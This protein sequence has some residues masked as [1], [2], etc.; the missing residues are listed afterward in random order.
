MTRLTFLPSLGDARGRSVTRRPSA[1]MAA[2]GGAVAGEGKEFK[3]RTK[4]FLTSIR[5]LRT[6]QNPARWGSARQ[7]ILKGLADEPFSFDRKTRLLH[8]TL[9]GLPVATKIGNSISSLL[10][11]KPVKMSMR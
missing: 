3:I 4:G 2:G 6:D 1:A 11:S 5:T 10:H 9:P 8:P 7:P